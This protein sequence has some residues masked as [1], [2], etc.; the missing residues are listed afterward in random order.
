MKWSVR[1]ASVSGIDIR[2]HA[3]FALIL[4]V[5]AIQWGLPHGGLGALFGVL[6]MLALFACVALHELGHSLV[7]QRFGVAVREILLLPIG[8]VARLS[9]EP[10]RPVHELLIA[11]AGPLV[12]VVIAFAI[13]ASA[14]VVF[15]TDWFSSGAFLTAAIGPPSLATM[16]ASL[17]IA[18]VALAVF[19]MLPAL[20]MDGGR[21]FRALLA[22]LLGKLKATLIAAT[23]GQLMA[24]GL[25]V[26]GLFQGNVILA[27]IGAFVFFGASQE[28]AAAR[29]TQT[30]SGLGAG[31]VVDPRAIVL[32]PGDLLGVALHHAVRAPQAHFA[33]IQ[34]DR[35]IGTLSRAEMLQNLHTLGPLTYVAGVMQRELAEVDAA[36]PLSEVRLRLLELGGRPVVVNGP[37]GYV[38][39]LGIED[40]ARAAM[41]ASA[42]RVRAASRTPVPSRD[43]LF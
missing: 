38:G 27:L 26:F 12:N 21:V 15:G 13:A 11:L 39:L 18:N 9:R 19:N 16:V 31:E 7:A 8:G 37:Y 29:A 34:G 4:L 28:R 10:S 22:M 14:L 41:M 5:G 35:V 2:V 33:V 20:P 25:A 6:F 40:L 1:V 24:A 42:L 3:S 43:S 17:L 36:M 30:L 23:V 32:A